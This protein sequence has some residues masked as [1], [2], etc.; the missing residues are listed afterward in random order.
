MSTEEKKPQVEQNIV[1]G[2]LMAELL[3][4][5][6]RRPAYNMEKFAQ[7]CQSFYKPKCGLSIS[8]SL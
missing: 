1:S 8:A 7:L 5:I 2:K 6:N 3:S 4:I